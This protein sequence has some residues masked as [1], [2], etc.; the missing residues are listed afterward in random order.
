MTEIQI[1]SA[2]HLPAGPGI[3]PPAISNPDG[4]GAVGL[5]H[6]QVTNLTRAFAGRVVLDA[7]SFSVRPGEIVVVTGPNGVGKSTLLK[8]LAGLL[9]PDS[10]RVDWFRGE[11]GP[12][13]RSVVPTI[14]YLA[15]DVRAYEELSAAENLDLLGRIRGVPRSEL[16]VA[17]RLAAVGLDASRTDAVGALSTG[18]RQRVKLALAQ[19][20]DP[21][22]LLLDEP[23]NNLDADG[24]RFVS[25]CLTRARLRGPV[26]LATN[27]GEEMQ[28]GDREFRLSPLAG[29]ARRGV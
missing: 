10:G 27:D 12:G 28:L 1:P 15:P 24:R 19:L 9:R 4:K 13:S 3:S 7:L 17:E 2:P 6:L 20:G 16:R 14:G 23:G 21:A 11:P 29:P 18:Q 5:V 8:I 26:I 25:E 22:V